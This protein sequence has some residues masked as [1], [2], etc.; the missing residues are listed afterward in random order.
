MCSLHLYLLPFVTIYLRAAN[1]VDDFRYLELMPPLP[2][3][4]S[5]LS[6]PPASLSF[7]LIPTAPVALHSSPVTGGKSDLKWT[8]LINA[9]PLFRMCIFFP[10]IADTFSSSLLIGEIPGFWQL[11]CLLA[12]IHFET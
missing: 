4:I 3:L 8:C 5:S 1:E 12:D 11:V 9:S 7:L 2:S 10:L 6:A